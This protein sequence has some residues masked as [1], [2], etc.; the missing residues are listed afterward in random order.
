MHTFY[1]SVVV[2]EKEKMLL[3]RGWI[4]RSDNKYLHQRCNEGKV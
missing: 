1:I 3:V 4:N 2:L